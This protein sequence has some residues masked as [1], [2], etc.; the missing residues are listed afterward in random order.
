M[1][2]TI[3]GIIF[4]CVS[5]LVSSVNAGTIDVD[6]TLSI[7]TKYVKCQPIVDKIIVFVHQYLAATDD[8]EKAYFRKKVKKKKK[9]LNKCQEYNEIP[10]YARAKVTGVQVRYETVY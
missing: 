2:R 9:K 4:L 10:K 3:N 7:S 1:N 5:L 8:H 6:L